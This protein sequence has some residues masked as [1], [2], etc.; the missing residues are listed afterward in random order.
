MHQQYLHD[1]T[2]ILGSG[3]TPDSW[4]HV[5]PPMYT[6][7]LYVCGKLSQYPSGLAL[8]VHINSSLVGPGHDWA[9]E[10]RPRVAGAYAIFDAA[11]PTP[12]RGILAA[13]ALRL[14]SRGHLERVVRRPKPKLQWDVLMWRGVRP[15]LQAQDKLPAGEQDCQILLSSDSLGM[16]YAFSR[17]LFEPEPT[18]RGPVRQKEPDLQREAERVI[19]NM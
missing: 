2:A 18:A 8:H 19:A 1:L 7:S 6:V 10:A 5:K 12:F 4:Q 11:D 3:C 17:V 15:G 14:P 9:P 13:A 16:L